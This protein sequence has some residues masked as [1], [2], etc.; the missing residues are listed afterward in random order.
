MLVVDDD[1]AICDTVQDGL[2]LSGYRTFRSTDGMDAILRV[3]RDEPDLVILDV[4]MPRIDGFEVLRRMRESGFLTP[5]IFL[6]ARHDRTDTV[7]GLRLGADDYVSKPFGL[8]ELLLRVAAVL[9]RTSGPEAR[10]RACG[11]IRIDDEA[12]EVKVEGD[13]IDLSPTEYRLLSYLVDNPNRVLT[14]EQILDVVWNIN[15][16]T[17]TT[18]VE[19]FISYLRRK[20]GPQVGL[21][22]K[23]VRGV[24]FKLV[25]K[26]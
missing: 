21:H 7:E 18:V 8:E 19:T 10:T 16:E 11:P 5:V 23:T 14:K 12:H 2:S 17:S 15:F 25:D 9:R 3:R 6:T 22:L 1:E 26:V 4:N 13:A 20:L 24:G